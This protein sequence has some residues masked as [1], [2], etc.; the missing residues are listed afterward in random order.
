[1]ADVNDIADSEL[2]GR[3]IR[4]LASRKRGYKQPLWTRVGDFF[5]LGSTYSMQL[6]RKYGKDPDAQVGK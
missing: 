4:H 3:V 1:M 5:C 2:V 6:C